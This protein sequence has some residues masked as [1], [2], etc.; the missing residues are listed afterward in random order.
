MSPSH[1]KS[2]LACVVIAV[3]LSALH[4]LGEPTEEMDLDQLDLNPR[5]TAAVK[6]GM[7]ME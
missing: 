5:I 3:C 2:E 7:C 1:R 6:K 4:A